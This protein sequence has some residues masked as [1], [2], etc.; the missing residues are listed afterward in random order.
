MRGE[1]EERDRG[2]ISNQSGLINQGGCLD[3]TMENPGDLCG[4]AHICHHFEG[5]CSY[6]PI[7]LA[8][9]I[10]FGAA[11]MVVTNAHALF[12]EFCRNHRPFP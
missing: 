3:R 7:S 1:T 8:G 2:L 6:V 11:V 9:D 4:C 12:Q 5:P 10:T